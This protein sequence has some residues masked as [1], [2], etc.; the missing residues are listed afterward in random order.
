MRIFMCLF[1]WCLFFSCQGTTGKLIKKTARHPKL[2]NVQERLK[3]IP[4]V[5]VKLEA[6]GECD[7]SELA[8]LKRKQNQPYAIRKN[9]LGDT[10]WISFRFIS[11][12]CQKFKPEFTLTEQSLFLDYEPESDH[13]CECYCAYR[14]RF[15]VVHPG[16]RKI[17]LKSVWL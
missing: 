5:S 16:G 4:E 3:P 12:C 15:I 1:G 2:E 17:R 10:T 6:I 7:K 13:I 14:Y 11:D 8:D 9:N